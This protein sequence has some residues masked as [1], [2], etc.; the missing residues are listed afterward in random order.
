MGNSKFWQEISKW[1][2]TCTWGERKSEARDAHACAGGF[3][4][5][6]LLQYFWNVLMNFTLNL[7]PCN[8]TVKCW[9]KS[10][11]LWFVSILQINLF[12]VSFASL[13]PGG[14]GTEQQDVD[15]CAGLNIFWFGEGQRWRQSESTATR[16][17]NQKAAIQFCS[18]LALDKT[19]S[20]NGIS[21]PDS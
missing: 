4:N 2:P 19:C 9:L 8:Y 3:A 20:P 7:D 6:F 5:T 13:S 12:D 21:S 17:C 15:P 10:S 1:C 16:V 18:R 14:K 11:R